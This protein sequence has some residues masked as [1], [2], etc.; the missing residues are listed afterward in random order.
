MKSLKTYLSKQDSDNLSSYIKFTRAIKG[1]KFTRESLYKN[2]NKLVEKD[3]YEQD[4]KRL[5]IDHL[6]FLSN[7]LEEAKN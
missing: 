6:Y 1:K 7:P 3:D 4:D 5:L 2:F